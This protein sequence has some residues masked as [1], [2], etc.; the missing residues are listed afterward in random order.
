MMKFDN[1]VVVITGGNSG[2]G[3]ASAKRFRELG[4]SIAISGRSAEKLDAA[5]AEL[6]V[7]AIAR[8]VD[9][10]SVDAVTAFIEEVVDAYGKI[11][12]VV[13]SAGGVTVRPF[14]AMDERLFDED[15][16]RNFKGAYFAAQRAIPRM[17]PGSSLIFLG[18]AAGRKGFQG[19][20]VY[21]PA[22]AALRNLVRVLAT[23][24]G[25]AGIR[26]NLVS[27]GPIPTPG[28]D[29]LGLPED[30]L[31]KAKAG[32]ASMVPL[33]RMGAAEDIADAI[34]YLASDEARYVNGAEIAVD[35]GM[36]Q[37]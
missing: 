18:S 36:A 4:A 24:L 5:K 21:G 2:I 19:M 9:V 1:K 22:K 15:L 14:A 28:M 3:L 17:R 12:V 20:S 33:G 7:G 31:E 25:D 32:F 34:V 23:E 8:S 6:G 37:V 27:P 13:A 30:E 29:R 26:A 10:T 11:D 35:G 16:D